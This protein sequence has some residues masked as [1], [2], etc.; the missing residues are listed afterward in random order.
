[1]YRDWSGQRS[2]YLRILG[3]RELL[4]KKN[5]L[6]RKSRADHMLRTVPTISKYSGFLWLVSTNTGIF[7][8]AL[9]LCE[10]SRT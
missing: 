9:K 4:K 7:L 8:R 10:E 5:S 2:L 6:V 1:M 3:L